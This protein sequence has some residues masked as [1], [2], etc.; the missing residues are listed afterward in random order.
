MTINSVRNAMSRCGSR[1]ICLVVLTIAVL[2]AAPSEAAKPRRR[3][4]SPAQTKKMQEEMAY[5]QSE[6]ARVQ[7]EVAAKERELVQ[8]FDEN[9]DGKLFGAEKAKYEAHMRDIRFGRAP[10]PMADIK[11]LGQGP[12]PGSAKK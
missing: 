4:P 1:A 3:G 12:R 10:N 11:P 2:F 5:Q 6:V 8:K 9:G 7:T